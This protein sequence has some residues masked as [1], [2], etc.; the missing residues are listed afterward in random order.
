[1][2]FEHQPHVLIEHEKHGKDGVLRRH[3][4]VITALT[5]LDHNRAIRTDHNFRKHEEA[6][7]EIERSSD[8]SGMRKY[9]AR[10]SNASASSGRSGRRPMRSTSRPIAAASPPRRRR[11]L[12]R[13]C[14]IRPD[15]G[16]ALN[17]ALEA[18][19]WQ[20][21]RGDKTRA[22]GRAYF[23]AIDPQGEAHELRRMMPVKAAE[24]YAR[25]ADVDAAHLPSVKE[26]RT[27]QQVPRRR[28]R[29]APCRRP[30]RRAPPA[31]LVLEDGTAVSAGLES[32]S[33]SS[34]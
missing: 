18:H 3:W 14:G 27:R 21:A 1:M 9:R 33:S 15:S 31:T 7:R 34:I 13:N 2:G 6:A 22:D 28:D 5:D 23:M 16:K 30:L 20:L 24:L 8:T 12:A 10:M 26:A 4:H 19:G 17:A 32:T 25:L 29:T 11:P